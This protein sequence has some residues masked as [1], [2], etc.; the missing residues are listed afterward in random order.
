MLIPRCPLLS[1]SVRAGTNNAKEPSASLIQVFLPLMHQPS[2]LGAARVIK[3][4]ASDPADGSVRASDITPSPRI[5]FG[6]QIDC[7]ACVPL[8]S[9]V[10]RPKPTTRLIIEP[11]K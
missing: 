2:P 3:A 9:R 1:G 7:C 10:I 4:P 8:F 11:T 6:I 5:N